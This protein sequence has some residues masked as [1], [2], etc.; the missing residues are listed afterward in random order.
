M[1]DRMER[2]V[3][4]KPGEERRSKDWTRSREEEREK[5]KNNTYHEG[6]D[7]SH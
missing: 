2:E 3:N 1:D 4:R 5:S 7:N 6:E